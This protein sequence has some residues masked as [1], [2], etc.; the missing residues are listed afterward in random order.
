MSVVPHPSHPGW[1]QIK[2]YP[3]GKR[4]GLKVLT[5]KGGSLANAM[6]IERNLRLSQ[7]ETLARID[8]HPTVAEAIPFFLADYRLEHLPSGVE[9][10]SR[11][12]ARWAVII[13]KLKFPALSV[14]VV[15][16]YKR[17]RIEQGIKPTTINKELSALSDLS[18]WAAGKGY[19]EQPLKIKRFP[20]KMTKAPLPDVPTREE[21]LSLIDSMI[22]PRCGLFACLYYGGLRASEALH[23]TADKVHLDIGMMRV[24]GKGNKERTVPI[25]DDL[26]P[27]LERRL[28][29]KETGLLWTSRSDAK[30]SG[31]RKII[32]LA[33]IRAGITRH[34]YPHLLRHAFGTHATMGGVGLR[35]LQKI[36][37]HTTSKTTEI[38]TTLSDQ[39]VISELTGKF[40]RHK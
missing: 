28:R 10:M 34:I 26:R 20:A 7:R 23:L 15:D 2:Y 3:D 19:C 13:G 33:S 5:L 8:L 6:S 39:A 12:M 35:T 40:G 27:Y 11:Y 17:R 18:K 36:M 29:E 9:V 31:L 14:V 30:M 4:G 16:D 37:G 1:W 32:Q 38:Y 21:V 22:W 24:R 25:V